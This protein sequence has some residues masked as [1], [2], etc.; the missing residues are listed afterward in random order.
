MSAMTW[1]TGPTQRRT[2]Q[3]GVLPRLSMLAAVVVLLGGYIAPAQAATTS[4]LQQLYFDNDW[5]YNYDF[6][7]KSVAG[8]NVDWDVQL[9]FW[10]NA[11]INTVKNNYALSAYFA[12][13][14]TMYARM[15]DGSGAVWD[16][17]NGRKTNY[18]GCVNDTRHY[19]IYADSDDRMGYD[20]GVGYFV[21]AT[22]HK[23]FD[24]LCNGH[25]GDSEG[26][27]HDIGKKFNSYWG[28][29]CGFTVNFDYGYFYNYEGN[30]SVVDYTDCPG[31]LDSGDSNHRWQTNGYATYIRMP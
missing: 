9:L 2:E 6:G 8:N 22:T 23:D 20:T 13:G 12:T 31:R 29:C 5:F 3:C 16:Q 21:F 14:G 10:N 7:S 28:G 15:N 26:T 1:A 11:K 4:H 25:F 17:D 18:V 19:R 24:E 30:C 27:E